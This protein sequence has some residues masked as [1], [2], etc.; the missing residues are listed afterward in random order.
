MNFEHQMVLAA[1][2]IGVVHIS[3]A[4]FAFKAQVGNKYTW[5]ARDE[6]LQPRGKAARL[7]RAQANFQET[8]PIF[9]ALIFVLETRSGYDAYSAWGAGIYVAAR[10]LFLPLY[11]FGVVLYRTLVWKVATT[12]IALIA[13]SIFV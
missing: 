9:L 12:G 2:L 10:A 5:G 6:G 1:S 11:A 8:F 7:Q 3:S 4:S 13:I